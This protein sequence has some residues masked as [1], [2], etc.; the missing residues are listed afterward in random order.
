MNIL[1][2][3]ENNN[4]ELSCIRWFKAIHLST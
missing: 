3:L 1:T 2:K 4:F